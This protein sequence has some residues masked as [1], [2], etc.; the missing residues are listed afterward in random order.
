MKNNEAIIYLV[1]KNRWKQ[2]YKKDK[3]GWVQITNG[4]KRRMTSEQ[5]ISHI[6][7]VIAWNKKGINYRAG[8][9]LIVKKRLK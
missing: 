5:L 2:V 4:I 3:K 8:S 9:K 1:T 7:P 6:L